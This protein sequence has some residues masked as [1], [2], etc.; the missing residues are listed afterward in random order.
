MSVND[1]RPPPKK[2]NRQTTRAVEKKE[3]EVKTNKN[4]TKNKQTKNKQT[5]TTTTGRGS[6]QAVLTWGGANR[7]AASV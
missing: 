5:K 4:K 6:F 7:V 1:V 2:K 3:G